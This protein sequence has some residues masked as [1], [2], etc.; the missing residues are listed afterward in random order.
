MI[1][2]FYLYHRLHLTSSTVNLL[3][4]NMRSVNENDII[5]I[6]TYSVEFAKWKIKSYLPTNGGAESAQGV[7][8]FTI[9]QPHL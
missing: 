8:N 3:L 1:Y 9:V 2:I 5:N 7:E 4:A 6:F